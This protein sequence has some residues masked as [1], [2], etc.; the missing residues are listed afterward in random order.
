MYYGVGSQ[1]VKRSRG[2]LGYLEMLEKQALEREAR[3]L[4]GEVDDEDGEPSDRRDEDEGEE[5]GPKTLQ[6]GDQ[7]IEPPISDK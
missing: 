1:Q 4:N 7:P 2:I 5:E 6:E 3:K